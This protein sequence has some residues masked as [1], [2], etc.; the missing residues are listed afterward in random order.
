M[1]EAMQGLCLLL[2]ISSSM[3][4]HG[5]GDDDIHCLSGSST[6]DTQQRGPIQVRD[7]KLNDSVLTF[8]PGVGLHFTEVSFTSKT[9][10][11]RNVWG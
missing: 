7:L 4:R 11:F 6:V 9:R 1:L 10:I 3:G 5:S 8:T 2:L